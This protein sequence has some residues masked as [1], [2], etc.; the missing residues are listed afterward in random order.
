MQAV[1]ISK[2][3]GSKKIELTH[4]LCKLWKIL[5]F[6]FFS[7]RITQYL[8]NLELFLLTF[9]IPKS[10]QESLRF[11]CS[12]PPASFKNTPSLAAD[13]YKVISSFSSLNSSLKEERKKI[14]EQRN[15]KQMYQDY[16]F[17]KENTWSY[18]FY[19]LAVFSWVIYSFFFFSF[20]KPIIVIAKNNKQQLQI[21]QWIFSVAQNILLILRFIHEIK[22]YYFFPCDAPLFILPYKK[23]T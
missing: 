9:L 4:Y 16:D 12:S 18:Y 10:T 7:V 13:S 11:V 2:K 14:I 15:S 17:Y 23:H 20:L 22:Y 6:F 8:Q 3:L 1:S 19:I 21:S 5:D